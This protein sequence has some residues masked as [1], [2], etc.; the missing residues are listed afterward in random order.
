MTTPTLINDHH[1]PHLVKAPDQCGCVGKVRRPAGNWTAEFHG[2]LSGRDVG[3]DANSVAV[4]LPNDAQE[5]AS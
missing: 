1:G 3:H 2:A 5:I 4:R